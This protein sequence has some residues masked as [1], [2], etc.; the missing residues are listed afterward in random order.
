MRI[1]KNL[2]HQSKELLCELVELP[3]KLADTYTE[4]NQ[5]GIGSLC[6]RELKRTSVLSS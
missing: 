1:H 4:F 6:T 2:G 3:S 5:G